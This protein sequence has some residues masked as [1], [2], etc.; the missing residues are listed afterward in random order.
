MVSNKVTYLLGMLV[1]VLTEILQLAAQPGSVMTKCPARD[2]QDY[3]PSQ[4]LSG[5]NVFMV[6]YF[7]IA[8][9]PPS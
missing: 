7:G 8:V 4:G 2:C 6:P 9:T 1:A 5:L 3:M